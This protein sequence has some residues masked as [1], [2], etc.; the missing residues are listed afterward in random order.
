MD[1]TILAK[2]DFAIGVEGFKATLFFLI[3]LKPDLVIGMRVSKS[4]EKGRWTFLM[5]IE[6]ADK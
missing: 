3:T 4:L 1:C 6:S 2:G 5:E